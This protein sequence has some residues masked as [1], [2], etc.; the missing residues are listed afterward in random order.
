MIKKKEKIVEERIKKTIDKVF[1][2]IIEASYPEMTGMSFKSLLYKELKSLLSNIIREIV[3]ED[4]KVKDW[5]GDYIGYNRA[6][7]E[8]RRKAR[9]LGLE[10]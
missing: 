7:Q 10:V 3:G 8:I 5:F 4:E 6:K 1:D 2:K 9:K